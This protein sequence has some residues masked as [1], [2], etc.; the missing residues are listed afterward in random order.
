MLLNIAL[1]LHVL[2]AG[3]G[4]VYIFIQYCKLP[5]RLQQHAEFSLSWF[6][7]TAF[8]SLLILLYR[9]GG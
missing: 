2:I 7:K 5:P 8:I 1:G 3:L 9:I 6:G 4:I